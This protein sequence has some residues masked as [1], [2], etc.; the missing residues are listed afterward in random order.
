MN[1][2]NSQETSVFKGTKCIQKQ[3]YKDVKCT[4]EQIPLIKEATMPLGGNEFLYLSFPYPTQSIQI[5]PTP[6]FLYSSLI[7]WYNKLGQFLFVCF[8]Q[9]VYMS[10]FIEHCVF[11][12][13]THVRD[14]MK[15]AHSEKR[16]HTSQ[17][18]Q[19]SSLDL[20]L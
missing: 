11:K 13:E 15:S 8:F 14:A 20:R 16:T 2:T 12:L 4:H 18:N 10:F 9:N 5:N 17:S 3:E 19:H 6:S 7:L 1:K